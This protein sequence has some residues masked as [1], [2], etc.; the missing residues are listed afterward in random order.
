M[1]VT[2]FLCCR[3]EWKKSNDFSFNYHHEERSN[4]CCVYIQIWLLSPEN[5][6]IC[7]DFLNLVILQTPLIMEMSL[8][9]LLLLPHL[10]GLFQVK[11]NTQ[12]GHVNN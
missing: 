11:N 6:Q 4:C 9:P 5:D 3:L 1:S 12:L 10:S 8:S 7:K 2:K